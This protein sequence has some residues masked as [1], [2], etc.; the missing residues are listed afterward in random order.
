MSAIILMEPMD[1]DLSDIYFHTPFWLLTVRNIMGSKKDC[2]P[3]PKK[4]PD[5]FKSKNNWMHS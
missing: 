2:F 5:W 1:P 3:N 4:R